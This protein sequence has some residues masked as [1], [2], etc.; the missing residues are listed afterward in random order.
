MLIKG[1]VLVGFLPFSSATFMMTTLPKYFQF[2]P[3]FL[4]K[5]LSH[6]YKNGLVFEGTRHT[7]PG[8]L[9]MLKFVSRDYKKDFLLLRILIIWGQGT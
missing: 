2:C 6:L 8:P 5:Q 3:C 1:R 9:A 4:F 7:L